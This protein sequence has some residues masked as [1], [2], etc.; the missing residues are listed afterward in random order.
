[1]PGD[2]IIIGTGQIGISCALNLAEHGWTVETIG[3]SGQPEALKQVGYR[4]ADRDVPGQLERAIGDGANLLIDTV[5]FD[6]SHGHQLGRLS[7]RF[8]AIAA[9]SSA[10]VYCDEQGRTLDEAAANG[11]PHNMIAITETHATVRAGPATYSTRKIAMEQALLDAAAH[12]AI[13][14]RPCAVHGPHSRHPREWWFVKRMLD[15][16]R[17]I[18]LADGGQSRFQTT[19]SVL[20]AALIAHIF[21]ANGRG[22]F[23]CSDADSPSVREIGSAISAMLDINTEFIS[24]PTGMIGRTPWSIPLPF[25]IANVA[26]NGLGWAGAISYSTNAIAAIKWLAGRKTEN[27]ETAFNQ[28]AAYPW[29][30]FDYSEEDAWLNSAGYQI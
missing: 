22:I 15:G 21:A 4:H 10:S 9:I 3:R 20:I 8:D 14:I 16:R 6:A 11:F 26:A 12:K 13:I 18:P 25:T 17:L 27:W 29:N 30:L 7:E 28:L 1:M 5:A 19:A 23:N 24:A 2:A